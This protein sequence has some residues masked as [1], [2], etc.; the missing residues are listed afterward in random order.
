MRWGESRSWR[1]VFD[2]GRRE[3][4][5]QDCVVWEEFECV[6]VGGCLG[7]DEDRSAG[8]HVRVR[9]RWSLLMVALQLRSSS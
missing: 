5:G 7:L 3:A 8:W 6:G 1:C 9:D 4:V 2:K